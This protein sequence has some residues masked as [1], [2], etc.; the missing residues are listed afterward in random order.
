MRVTQEMLQA[1]TA[2]AVEL[3]V[4]PRHSQMEDL[5]TNVELMQEILEAALD[6]LDSR[7]STSAD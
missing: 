5:A 2:K 7:S 3:G 4:L 6:R 1:A